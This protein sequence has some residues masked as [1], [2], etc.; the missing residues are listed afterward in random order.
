MLNIGASIIGIGFGVHYTI[1]IIRNLQNPILIIKAP[2]LGPG[3]FE[4]LGLGLWSLRLKVSR[5]GDLGVGF[6]G[7]EAKG[8]R[9]FAV[10]VLMAQLFNP[11]INSLPEASE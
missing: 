5:L 2:T 7:I 1:I 3:R 8:V 9:G 4:G 11:R 10:R 6:R